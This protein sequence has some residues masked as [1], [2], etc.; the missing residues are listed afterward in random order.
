MLLAVGIEVVLDFVS[1]GYSC[2]VLGFI[3]LRFGYVLVT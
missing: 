3:L 2:F 1:R